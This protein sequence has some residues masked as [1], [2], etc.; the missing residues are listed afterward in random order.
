[1]KV[2]IGIT[3]GISAYKIYDLIRLFTKNGH[4]VKVIVT[5]NAKHFVEPLV[6]ETLSKNTC[7]S[8]MFSRRTDVVHI[9]L[10][11]WADIFVLAPATA[12]IIGKISHGIADDLLST[13]I[14]S[15][16]KVPCIIFPAMN[17]VM[18]ASKVVVDNI[19]RLKS[20]GYFIVESA[21]GS[22]ACGETGKGRLPDP[23][24]IFTLT[25]ALFNK[26]TLEESSRNN[27]YNGKNIMITAGA[28]KA[29]LDPVRYITNSASGRTG[30]ELAVSLYLRGAN[31]Y[32]IADKNVKKRFPELE[33]ITCNFFEAET[34][35]DVYKKALEHFNKI[36]IYIST[37]ALTDFKNSPKKNKIKK[38]KGEFNLTIPAGIDVFQ[39]LSKARNKQVMVGF[40]L[41]TENLIDNAIEKMK[42]KK[43]DIIV[44]NKA[45]SI[46]SEF[47]SAF[48]IDSTG[49]KQEIE[50]CDKG[51]FAEK[52]IRKI[53]DFICRE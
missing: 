53:E 7:M 52:L 18:Y 22:L 34:T 41:E 33:I 1:M 48:I 45:A 25:R 26:T 27:F 29:F 39:E 24:A 10:A 49:C 46:N 17:S 4:E 8:D 42:N 38:S 5:E 28:T 13:A 32:F 6:I 23:E 44:A 37:A 31:V 15:M 43:M 14:I 35:E 9:E 20:F 50:E 51:I 21:S 11:R 19:K 36:D 16:D 3:G 12:N 40:A 2:L 47:T 30:V